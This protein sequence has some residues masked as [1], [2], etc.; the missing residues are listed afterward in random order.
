MSVSTQHIIH[1]RTT[2]CYTISR[3]FERS[4][5]EAVTDLSVVVD[6]IDFVFWHG[7]L[8][9]IAIAYVPEKM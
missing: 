8:C 6:P 1:A 5:Y 3:L 9:E 4:V 2:L 7:I